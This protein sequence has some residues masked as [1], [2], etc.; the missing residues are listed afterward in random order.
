MATLT[1]GSSD[2]KLIPWE[3]RFQNGQGVFVLKKTASDTCHG[4]TLIFLN[5]VVR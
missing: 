4:P 3:S 2:G 5:L 1:R